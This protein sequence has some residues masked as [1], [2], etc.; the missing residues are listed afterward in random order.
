MYGKYAALYHFSYLSLGALTPMIGQY[1]K[2]IGFSGTQIGTITA[3]GTA[4]AIIASTFWGGVYSRCER[5]QVLLMMLCLSAA[6]VCAVF[7]QATL[8]AFVLMLFGMMYFFQAP[9]MSLTDAFTMESSQTFG[10]LRAW[11]AVG[12]AAGVFLTGIL[13]EYLG[14]KLIFI[15]YIGG[16]IMA[17]LMIYLIRRNQKQKRYVQT[18]TETQKPICSRECRQKPQKGYRMIWKNQK[19]RRLI[20]CA[21]FMGGTNVANNTYFSFL[22]IEGGGT[23]AGVGI[24]MLLMVGS[25]VPFMAWCE[26]LSRRFTLQKTILAAMTISVVRFLLYAAGLPWWLLIALFF[27]QGAVNGILLIE[28]VRYA[29]LLAPK[30]NESLAISSYYIIGSNLSTICCQLAGGVLLDAFGATG[31]YLFFG[32]FNLCGVLLY[33]KFRLY[34]RSAGDKTR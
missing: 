15:F 18:N 5:K 29:A 31:V 25:E 30:G 28:F 4:V 14:L 20:L 3:T 11:G 7:S 8:Y 13:S 9:I 6:A 1:L 19:L 27:S 32:L 22:Y 34:R 33:W 12:F 2:S 26:K 16:F 17:A 23:V 10:G 24:A 21:F